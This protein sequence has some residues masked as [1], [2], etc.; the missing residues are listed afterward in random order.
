[1]GS[2]KLSAQLHWPDHKGACDWVGGAMDIV[3][4]ELRMA[5][6]QRSSVRGLKPRGVLTV[7]AA[8]YCRS[9][10]GSYSSCAH[11]SQ[12]IFGYITELLSIRILNYEI[13]IK[14]MKSN[15]EVF[16]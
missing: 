9:C 6:L 3:V 7:A 15:C 14:I 2:N 8:H 11:G 5:T 1:M 4:L 12:F 13:V 10:I 16:F